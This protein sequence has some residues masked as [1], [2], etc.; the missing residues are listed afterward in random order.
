MLQHWSAASNLARQLPY[1]VRVHQLL[2][3]I[4]V[5]HPP[6]GH[7][8]YA[9]TL[10]AHLSHPVLQHHGSHPLQFRGENAELFLKNYAFLIENTDEHAIFVNVK[11]TYMSY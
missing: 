7:P 3:D 2:L 11:T 4:W 5:Y 6:H 10:H 9:R 1:E 8:V